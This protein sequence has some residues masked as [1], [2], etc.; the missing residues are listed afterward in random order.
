MSNAKSPR[1]RH[2]TSQLAKSATARRN[3]DH[4]EGVVRLPLECQHAAEGQ[5]ELGG[6]P[7]VRHVADVA[8]APRIAPGDLRPLVPRGWAPVCQE[9]LRELEGALSPS[10]T[11]QRSDDADLVRRVLAPVDLTGV[12]LADVGQV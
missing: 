11:D 10:E 9:E 7:G 3:C 2:P 6:D 1:A 4:D 5:H 12:P 8:R